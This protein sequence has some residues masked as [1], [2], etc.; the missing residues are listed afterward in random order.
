M[1]WAFHKPHNYSWGERF[2]IEMVTQRTSCARYLGFQVG[3]EV[4]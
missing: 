3:F 1:V 2:K 4:P